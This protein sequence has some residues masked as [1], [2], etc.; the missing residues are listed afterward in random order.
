MGLALLSDLRY[1]HEPST[2]PCS[3]GAYI[4]AW[5]QTV[6]KKVR[7]VSDRETLEGER[8]EMPSVGNETVRGVKKG[9]TENAAHVDIVEGEPS[10]QRRSDRAWCARGAVE[11]SRGAGWRVRG[12]GRR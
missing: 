12:R 2:Q 4:L 9:P 6:I 5:R 10:W 3:P 1:I 7:C 11:A 8:E